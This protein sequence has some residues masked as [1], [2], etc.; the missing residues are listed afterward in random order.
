MNAA[1]SRKRSL[2]VACGIVLVLLILVSI[3]VKQAGEPSYSGRSLGSWLRVLHNPRSTPAQQQFAQ[4][5]I[6]AMG[7]NV[8]PSLLRQL[9]LFPPLENRGTLRIKALRIGS[10]GRTRTYNPPVNSR[11][12]YH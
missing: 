12:L 7:T 4:D 3:V 11:L 2:A 5:A 9:G 10:K 8:I 1:F 6:R